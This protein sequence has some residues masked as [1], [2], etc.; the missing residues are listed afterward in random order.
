M[1]HS[2]LIKELAQDIAKLSKT[3]ST[4]AEEAESA[5]MQEAATEAVNKKATKTT[6][7]KVGKEVSSSDASQEANPSIT[8]EAV[9][10]VLAE[11]SQA[12]GTTK[13]KEL[14]TKF[15]AAKLSAV[16]PS[17]YSEL[18]AAANELK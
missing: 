11:V 13:V 17:R 2:S 16:D 7:P 18:L 1:S 10:A 12:G 3:L 9:R 8:I 4:L 15:G 5:P 6:Q 14:L